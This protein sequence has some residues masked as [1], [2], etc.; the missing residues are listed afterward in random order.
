MIITDD[1]IIIGFDELVMIART[2]NRTS[3]GI[4]RETKPNIFMMGVWLGWLFAHNPDLSPYI[5]DITQIRI[6]RPDGWKPGDIIPGEPNPLPT[7]SITLACLGGTHVLKTDETGEIVLPPEL[8]QVETFGDTI[9]AT[10]ER[11][12]RQ[13]KP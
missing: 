3:P 2:Y 1:Y 4:L 5:P 7:I 13:R 9:V 10:I 11:I 12:M 6:K 8:Q